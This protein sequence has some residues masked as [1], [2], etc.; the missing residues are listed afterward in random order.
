MNF[1]EIATRLQEDEALISNLKSK[2]VDAFTLTK[3]ENALVRDTLVFVYTSYQEKVKLAVI[4]KIKYHSN[5]NK[6]IIRFVTYRTKKM[7]IRIAELKN[8][9]RTINPNYYSKFESQLNSVSEL[10]LYS[11][12]LTDR[13]KAAHEQGSN[14]EMC[15]IT[16]IKN[17]HEQAKHILEKFEG[18]MW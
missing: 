15:T 2:N 5:N 1:A 4:N 18:S 16:E 17:A 12:I 3:I 14:L 8:M 7:D 6:E 9:L 11:S 10:N 13:V